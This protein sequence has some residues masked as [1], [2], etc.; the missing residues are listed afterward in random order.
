MSESQKD[1]EAVA[2]SGPTVHGQ[3]CNASAGSAPLFLYSNSS[4]LPSQH[5]LLNLHSCFNLTS[6]IFSQDLMISLDERLV[7]FCSITYHHCLTSR[8]HKSNAKRSMIT[9]KDT[10]PSLHVNVS[11]QLKSRVKFNATPAPAVG[12]SGTQAPFYN[13][14]IFRGNRRV[15]EVQ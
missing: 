2:H 10:S 3:G 7:Y 6:L 4:G 13:T 14:T 5:E 15:Y 11:S 9:S 12:N 1:Q 8:L